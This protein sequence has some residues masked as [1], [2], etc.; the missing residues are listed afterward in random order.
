MRFTSIQNRLLVIYTRLLHNLILSDQFEGV[1]NGNAK[2]FPISGVEESYTVYKENFIVFETLDFNKKEL[3]REW[4]LQLDVTIE[5][6]LT[7]S[8][9]F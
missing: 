2:T 7:P 9:S 1:I 3:R 6:I 8:L 4:T 5:V